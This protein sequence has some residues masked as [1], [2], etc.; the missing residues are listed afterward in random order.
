MKFSSLQWKTCALFQTVIIPKE[1]KLNC[2]HAT[3]DI[4][5]WVTW[6]VSQGC[7]AHHRW[8]KC[9][10][11]GGWGT[12]KPPFGQKIPLLGKKAQ[13]PSPPYMHGSLK[14]VSITA[15]S[16]L[17]FELYDIHLFLQIQNLI[18][19]WNILD[20]SLTVVARPLLHKSVGI[21]LT[22]SVKNRPPTINIIIIYH[23]PTTECYFLLE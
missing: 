21:C 16:I 7:G 13:P 6:H 23:N 2:S 3:P 10:W 14:H 5:L 15:D 12:C 1:W 11:E 19:R 22:V 17:W 4:F 18:T 9:G 8:K 20:L